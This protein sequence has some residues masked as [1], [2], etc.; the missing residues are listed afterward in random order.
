MHTQRDC[1]GEG[2]FVSLRNPD[3]LYCPIN[4]QKQLEPPISTY[5]LSSPI[6]FCAPLFFRAA[7]CTN[8]A[9]GLSNINKQKDV[10]ATSDVPVPETLSEMRDKWCP[11]QTVFQNDKEIGLE[12]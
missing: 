9:E 4:S 10:T 7:M 1:F 6:L 5:I 12:E 2:S 8:N 3:F 11:A